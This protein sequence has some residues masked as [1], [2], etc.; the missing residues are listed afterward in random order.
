MK[1]N[2]KI[3]II[4]ILM[5]VLG[6]FFSY[7]VFTN[8]TNKEVDNLHVVDVIRINNMDYIYDSITEDQHCS[9]VLSEMSETMRYINI[10]LEDVPKAKS[11]KE[12]YY[13][14]KGA[15]SKIYSFTSEKEFEK[16]YKT[17]KPIKKLREYEL[18]NISNISYKYKFDL[19][20]IGEDKVVIPIE[21]YIND[22]NKYKA[23]SYWNLK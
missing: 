5:I 16:F 18:N 13:A 1:K 23:T 20:L 6:M 21:L 4:F 7:K 22:E 3:T 10:I 11:I 9:T 15:I 14:N 2:F 19:K 12:Y 8:N 17:I